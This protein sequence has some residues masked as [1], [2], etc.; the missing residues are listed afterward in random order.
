MTA[1]TMSPAL[2]N[3]LR[4]FCASC[5]T[6]F[7][8]E[9]KLA[10]AVE[11]AQ[12]PDP[13]PKEAKRFY[14]RMTLEQTQAESAVQITVENG[15]QLLARITGQGPA[16]Q[17]RVS[18]EECKILN[19]ILQ[20]ACHLL[21]SH[22][23]LQK[24]QFRSSLADAI[25]WGP[26]ETLALTVSATQEAPIHFNLLINSELLT[27]LQAQSASSP[28]PRT[29]DNLALLQDVELDVTLRFGSRQLPLR[30]IAEIAAGSVI[31]LD[32]KLDEPAELLLGER[33]I[34]RGE[35][36]VV[37]GNYGLRITDIS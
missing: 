11:P 34:A 35:V 7:S 13:S 25:P 12:T 5:S 30:E 14:M 1:A 15:V 9:A 22:A 24:L 2:H 16:A 28:S 3:F 27:M 36:V 21:V 23:P 6:L 37:D 8:E 31:E 29:H 32:K 19:S 26:A 10:I 4:A 20:K 18:A 33:V 17:G